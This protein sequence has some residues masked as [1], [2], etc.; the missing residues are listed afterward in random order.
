MTSPPEN[1]GSNLPAPIHIGK[2]S[3]SV[4]SRV[5]LQLGRESISSSITALVE[6]VKNAYDA[7]AEEIRVRFSNIGSADALIVIEDTGDGMSVDNL[8][9]YWMVIG[10][11]N[12]TARKKTKKQR[13]V[14]GE[15][16]LGRLGLDRLCSRT[17][18]ESI[19][20]GAAEGIRLDV[21]WEK[22]EENHHRLESVEHDLYSIPNLRLD[23]ITGKWRDYPKGT[24]LILRGLKDDW[25]ED[26]IRQL[27]NELALLVSPF[28]GINDFTI[29]IDT[30]GRWEDLDGSVST[31]K[32]LLDGA[33]WKVV[34]ELD[35]NDNMEINMTSARHGTEYHMKPTRWVDAIKKQGARSHCGPF[36]FEFY[37][38]VRKDAELTNKTLKAHE[39]VNFLKFNQGIRI[40]RD[41]FRVKPY[42]EP[43]GNG[44]WL[45]LAFRRM[46]N[47]EGVSQDLRPGNWR[48]GYNQVVGA[49]FITHEKNSG[50]NDQTNREGLLQGKAF[51]HLY[52]FSLRVIQFFEIHNQIF[53]RSRKL[54]RA[55]ADQAEV[56]A[57]SSIDEVSEAIKELGQLTSRIPNDSAQS[58]DSEP[59]SHLNQDDVKKVLGDVQRR[60]EAAEKGLEKSAKLFRDAE[61]QKNTMANL[62]SLGILAASF[63]HET[64]DWTGT[65]AKNSRWLLEIL[66]KELLMI[67][68]KIE[69]EITDALKDTASEAQ[70]IRKFA[71]FTL[72]NL[73]R[74]KRQRRNFSLST[75]VKRVCDAFEEV[76]RL[77]RHT[78]FSFNGINDEQCLINGFEMDWESIIVN[79]ITNSSW[80]LDD[81]PREDRKILLEIVDG[82]SEWVLTF[83]DSGVGLEAGTEEMVF[84]PAFSTKRTPRGEVVG[85]GMGLFIVKSFVEEHSNG[86]ITAR[87]HGELG[88]A[89]FEIR[90]PKAYAQNQG[91]S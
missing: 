56:A 36:R 19:R 89:S 1:E 6:L 71:Q 35:E 9:D 90:V 72:G 66:P 44:D 30:Q 26:S 33:N 65:V 37:F 83:D 28:Q 32:M 78:S 24:R 49:A 34:A 5:A 47:P 18:L 2:A 17:E 55:P 84:L 7:D 81:K 61:E 69:A 51:D 42:G 41:G 38:F 88:G 15:K 11:A 64:L 20:E 86:T 77:Q 45:R 76:I 48:V 21:Q 31:Q 3:F 23:P 50:L 63:G 13:V 80:A 4:S 82:G 14:T 60:L 67:G 85:T 39:I 75:T 8:R 12:K 68:P 27:R 87:C 29:S 59:S 22:Y 16:G 79:L 91:K 53:E 46:Q 25:D 54:E 70:K 58:A 73:N 62:A 57:K 74:D 43:D 10:T 52:V 40:Y